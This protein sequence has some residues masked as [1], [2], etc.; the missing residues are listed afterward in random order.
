M[1]KRFLLIYSAALILAVFITYRTTHHDYYNAVTVTG[2]TPTAI[3]ET[4]PKGIELEVGGRVKKTYRF[5]TSSLRAF[6]TTRIRT[7]EISPKGDFLGTYSYVGIPVFN[8]LEGVAPSFPKDSPRNFPTDF[9]VTFVS[10]TGE[11]ALFSY[12][13]LLMADDDSPVTLAF[14]RKELLPSKEPENYTLNRFKGPLAGLRLIAPRDGD[15]ARYLDNV[16]S[17]TLS[18]PEAGEGLVPPRKKNHDCT[19]AAITIIDGA[20]TYLASDEGV[21]RSPK[22]SWVKVG[23]GQGYK[24]T[25]AVEGFSLKSFLQKNLPDLSRDDFFLFVSCDGYRC[26]FSGREIFATSSGHAMVLIDVM[27]GKNP[28]GGLMLACTDDYFIDRSIWGVSHLLI[29]RP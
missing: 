25:S 26:L 5:S 16:V 13:E 6:A 17:V 24:G 8:I 11:K 29:V 15:T 23:H 3:A 12:G 28:S 22:R 14:H 21:E 7:K 10:I 2:A 20:K 9:L 1:K 18:V 27:N 4:V 19:S